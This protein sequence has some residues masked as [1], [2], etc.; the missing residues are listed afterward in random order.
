MVWRHAG[1]ELSVKLGP[2]TLTSWARQPIFTLSAWFK[3]VI[4]MH[5]T[6]R[7]VFKSIGIFQLGRGKAPAF[8]LLVGLV[9]NGTRYLHS[10]SERLICFLLRTLLPG[11]NREVATI[12][13][14]G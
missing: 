6:T 7:G 14:R 9:R 5:P 8:H 10:S 4:S 3:R 12:T 2:M 13:L 1:P 11:H